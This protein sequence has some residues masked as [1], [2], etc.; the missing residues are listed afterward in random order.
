MMKTA[1]TELKSF[2]E[3]EKSME[4]EFKKDIPKLKN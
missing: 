4:I 3:L 1:K 2:T